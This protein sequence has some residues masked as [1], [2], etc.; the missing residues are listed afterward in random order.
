MTLIDKLPADAVDAQ[1]SRSS[2]IDVDSV[3]DIVIPV[4]N[5]EVDL[6]PSVT[7]LDTYLRAGFPYPYCITIADNASTDSTWAV[8]QRL[9]AEL[10]RVRAVHLAEKGRGRA[11]KAVWSASHAPILA[12]MDVDLA[13]DLRA[14]LPLVAPLISGHSD[15]AI[16]TRLTRSSR[17]VRGP[18]REFISRSYNLL[19]RGTLAI[20]FSDAQCGFKAISAPVAAELL[21]LVEDNNWF[22]DTELLVLAQ[23]S[24]LRIHE[25]PVD[26][27]DDPDSRVNIVATAKE[28]L[29]GI[30][31]LARGLVSGGIPVA[32]MRAEIGYARV[33]SVVPGV[34]HGL[35]GQLVRF[36][37]VGVLSTMAYFLLYLG[38]REITGAQVANLVALLVTAVANTATNRRMTFGVSGRGDL[39]KHHA[40]GLLAFGVGLLLT[41]GSLWLLHSRLADPS[42]ALEVTVLVL[43]NA[44]STVVRFLAL[45]QLMKEPA[46]LTS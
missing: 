32:R 11:L 29:I 14:L 8:A 13:T 4:Y 36:G 3:V 38:L 34:P 28:D 43:A 6:G 44:L 16:G 35:L 37:V 12:Y 33:P 45:R 41:S 21:P 30:A 25:V 2:S 7:R 10:P 40:G 22:F 5:E 24:G 23:R 19:L 31:R 26:W 17:V 46:A 1:L 18:K 15:V 39:A 20:S 27:I 9:A 42:R